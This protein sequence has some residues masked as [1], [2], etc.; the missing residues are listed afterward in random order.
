VYVSSIAVHG[1]H[2]PSGVTEQSPCELSGRDYSDSKILA[3]RLLMEAFREQRFPVVVL[4]PSFVWGPR[5]SLFT[6]RPLLEMKQG[7]FL[8]V[9]QGR[10]HCHAVHVDNLVDA[11][12]LAGSKPG[13]E[14]KSFLITDGLECT[15]ADF[16]NHYLRFLGLATPRSLD[17][18]SLL[19]HQACRLVDTLRPQLERLKGNPAPL[20]RKVVRRILSI[21]LRRLESRYMSRWDL[22][23][24]ARQGAVDIS[25]ARLHLG[26][27]PSRG[28]DDGMRE[29]LAWVADQLAHPLG[30]PDREAG[31]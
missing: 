3:E 29:T 11:L 15:W 22:I 4:R 1:P 26:Y 8:F 10:G 13:V 19:T 17:S 9:D 24:Y 25:A 5:S 28:L 12:L 7:R 31:S 16:F 21:L 23:K 2:P 14:G 27:Q 18:S 30:L 6:V 20:P